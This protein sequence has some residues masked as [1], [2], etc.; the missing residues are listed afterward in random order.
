M[1]DSIKVGDWVEFKLSKE[2]K[3]GW[4]EAISGRFYNISSPELISKGLTGFMVGI[5]SLSAIAIETHKSDIKDF[6]ELALQTDD[7][8][9]FNELALKLKSQEA[10]KNA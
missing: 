9:W 6:I 7:K 3:T 1:S 4:V 2:V 10:E 8:E 5:K